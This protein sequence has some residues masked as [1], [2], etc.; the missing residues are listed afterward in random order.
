MISKKRWFHAGALT[1]ALTMVSV[2]PLW[3]VDPEQEQH[4]LNIADKAHWLMNRGKYQEAVKPAEEALRLAEKIYT[5]EE[6]QHNLYATL[7]NLGLIYLNLRRYAEAETFLK[8]AL[9]INEKVLGPNN[10]EVA[11]DINNLAL[12]Y[13]N[14]G[15]YTQAE[16]LHKRALGIYKKT[17][18][19]GHPSAVRSLNN[20]TDLYRKMGRGDAAI[21]VYK[22]SIRLKPDDALAYRNLGDAYREK[23]QYDDAIVAYKEAIRLKPDDVVA[24]NNLGVAYEKKGQHDAAIASYK[25]AIRL[26]QD[27][28]RGHSNLANL[29][30][31]QGQYAKAEPHYKK[32]LAIRKEA[33]RPDHPRLAFALNQLAANYAAQGQHNEAESLYQR[34]Y[35]ILKRIAHPEVATVLEG[36]AKLYQETGRA[37]EAKKLLARAKRSA[38]IKKEGVRLKALLT[39]GVDKGYP[40]DDVTT[41]NVNENERMYFYSYWTDI[42]GAHRVTVK[43][44]RPDKRLFAEN[45]YDAHFSKNTT[46]RIWHRQKIFKNIPRG[47]W[48]SELYLD[49]KR[50]F[51]KKF[52]VEPKETDQSKK[53][54]VRAKGNVKRKSGSGEKAGK[55]TPT[56]L[57]HAVE[58]KEGIRFKVM[59]T[60]G[61]E[62]NND[63]LDF[64]TSFS[65]R[66]GGKMYVFIYWFDMVGDHRVTVKWIKP[67]QEVFD[68]ETIEMEFKNP[69][70]RT[71][72]WPSPYK[73]RPT[74]DWTFELHFDG[75]HLVTKK[76][77]V[78]P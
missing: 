46:K 2:S 14:Q 24:H 61:L 19:L 32:I 35:R 16:T 5:E 54:L 33:L 41:F 11:M 55:T 40:I 63:P 37:D 29:Y 30:K 58:E 62:K 74:G 36:M 25:E 69:D 31:K 66:D 8:R 77:T 60:S 78:T 67:D 49:G 70:W 27:Y 4:F 18:G 22:E 20:L 15:Q 52:T 13:Q 65:V 56:D 59:M 53:L 76:F 28:E 75:K 45:I 3:S 6:D 9:A 48:T 64:K 39:S 47:V 44:I 7:N 1:I 72:L 26:K 12:A 38:L 23:S 42:V 17:V 10:F 71:W 51:T 73:H 34:A 50:L 57:I 68:E 21:A 43:W